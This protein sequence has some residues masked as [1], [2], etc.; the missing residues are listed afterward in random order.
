MSFRNT[1]HLFLLFYTLLFFSSPIQQSYA[2]NYGKKEA[3]KRVSPYNFL[4]ASKNQNYYKEVYLRSFEKASQSRQRCLKKWTILIYMAA[5]NDLEPYAFWDLY[6]L[7]SGFSKSEQGGSTRRTDVLVQLDTFGNKGIRRYHMFQS[8]TPYQRTPPLSKKDFEEYSF[9]QIQSPA[10]LKIS[11]SKEKERKTDV[12]KDLYSFLKWGI[13][14]YPSEHYMVVVWGHGQGFAPSQSKA[15]PHFLNPSD[16]E[17][18]LNNNHHSTHRTDRSPRIAK[19]SR[20]GGLAFDDTQRTYLDTPT[21]REVFS[22]VKNELLDGK[23]I[24]LY[25]SDACLMQSVEVAAELATVTRFVVGSAQIQNFLG[26]PYRRILREINTCRFLEARKNVEETPRGGRKKGVEPIREKR[27]ID[28]M[29][30]RYLAHNTF[31]EPY[32]LSRMLPDIARASFQSQGFQGGRFNADAKKDFTLSSVSTAELKSLLVPKLDT[33]SQALDNYLKEDDLRSLDLEYILQES[34]RGF[35]GG[36]V[37]L[38]A[39]LEAIQYLLYE[40]ARKTGEKTPGARSLRKAIQESKQALDRT[41]MAY[42]QGV[43]YSDDPEDPERQ[44][45]RAIR[46]LSIW[47]PSSE[48]GYRERIQNFEKSVF[49]NRTP[50]WTNWMNEM[51]SGDSN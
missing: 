13:E 1:M 50:H 26:L 12:G 22:K 28:C 18:L 10:I 38:Y 2:E 5:D 3:C 49:F 20:F 30:E 21:L 11:G 34:A 9:E 25:A 4:E 47:M 35:A 14:N 19:V 41:L 23:P 16:L 37:D 36:Q 42:Q 17:S 48:S 46:G 40:E 43:E 45:S 33:F 44:S 29:I 8:P 6:E 31:D 39:A 51:Y 27:D 7:E 24:D 15:K 32:L